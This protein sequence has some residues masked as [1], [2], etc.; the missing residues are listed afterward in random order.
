MNR[1]TK[2]IEAEGG[3]TEDLRK[4]FYFLLGFNLQVFCVLLQALISELAD[5]AEA[6]NLESLTV[7]DASGDSFEKLSPVA[8]RVLPAIRQYFAWIISQRLILVG[9][10]GGVDLESTGPLVG[11]IQRMWK[12]AADTLTALVGFFPVASLPYL[13]YLL[14]EDEQTVGF[15]PLRDP[16][17]GLEEYS[18]YTKDD[19]SLKARISDGIIRQSDNEN[20]ARIRDILRA[21][22]ALH[23]EKPCPIM[24]ADDSTFVYGTEIAMSPVSDN[25]AMPSQP[26]KPAYAVQNH[27]SINDESVVPLDSLGTMDNEMNRMVDDLLEPARFAPSNDTSYG[28]NSST[29]NAIFAP[30]GSERTRLS[31]SNQITPTKAIPSLPSIW[32]SPFTPKPNELQ[33][34]SPERLSNSGGFPSMNYSTNGDQLAAAAALDQMTGM[35]QRSSNGRSTKARNQSASFDT[36]KPVNQMLQESLAKQFEPMS[37]SSSVFSS[38]SSIYANNSPPK[39]YYGRTLNRPS[40][41]GNDSTIYPGASDFDRTTMLQSSLW[42]SS[43]TDKDNHTPP[44]GQGRRG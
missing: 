10:A 1:L 13:P 31:T 5:A 33:P 43:Q 6:E 12:T 20:Y 34:I 27:N 40:F 39:S 35:Q 41:N 8:I 24:M 29:A 28:M 16:P 14:P 11:H 37:L 19:G 21:G 4:S 15:K 3:V 38:N 32:G 30:I 2:C 7:T 25:S 42:N 26:A 17:H 44:A 22:M 9:L 23:F 18:L 36:S